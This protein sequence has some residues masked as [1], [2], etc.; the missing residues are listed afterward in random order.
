MNINGK[1]TKGDDFEYFDANETGTTA[2]TYLL[3]FACYKQKIKY[4]A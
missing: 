4:K 3:I 2:W 1:D